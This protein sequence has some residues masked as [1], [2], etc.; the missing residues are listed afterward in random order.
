MSSKTD[1]TP[2]DNGA[3][4]LFELEYFGRTT[5]KV[6][7]TRMQVNGIHPTREAKDAMWYANI[8]IRKAIHT[9]GQMGVAK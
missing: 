5:G 6:K 7:T 3:C 4:V 9:S 1:F 2:W 8:A